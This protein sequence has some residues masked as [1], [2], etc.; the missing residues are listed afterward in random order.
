MKMKK[1]DVFEHML[2]NKMNTLSLDT[3]GSDCNAKMF[4]T[5]L[6]HTGEHHIYKNLDFFVRYRPEGGAGMGA[7]PANITIYI[8]HTFDK[9]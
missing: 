7:Y 8:L 4:E 3:W 6:S 9:E 2:N 1:A 5:M